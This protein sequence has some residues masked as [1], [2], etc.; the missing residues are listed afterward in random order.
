M[1]AGMRYALLLVLFTACAS[2]NAS[3]GDHHEHGDHAHG[4]HTH[5]DSTKGFHHRFD[6]AEKWSKRFDDPKRDAWQMPETVVA[7]ATV[8]PGATVADIG[9]GTGYF[10]PHLSRAV[11]D[12]GRVLA[13]DV[14]AT[15]VAHMTKRIADEALENTTAS[16]VAPDDPALAPD[17]VDRI[18]VVD[19]WHHIDRRIDYTAKLRRALK[20]GGKLVVV[21]FT[22]DSPEGPPKEHRLAPEVVAKELE[23]AGLT[24]T[25][26]EEPLPRQ[27]V[28]IGTKP[29]A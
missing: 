18:L 1:P 4:D 9:A 8:E 10:L 20:A 7:L 2:S 19:T 23:E 28:V 22:L 11:G 26:A 13:L 16:V 14:E 5:G 25:I 6:D 24:A 3:H 27:Y 17:S 21:D 15:L 12:D 29:G